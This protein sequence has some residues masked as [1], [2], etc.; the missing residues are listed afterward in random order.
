MA[1]TSTTA[2]PAQPKRKSV[3]RQ[4]ALTS[5]SSP[6]D[7]LDSLLRVT[8]PRGWLVLVALLAV[9][10][11][12]VLYGFVGAVPTTVSGQG[13]F[14]PPGGLLSV[15][16]PR[17]GTVTQMRGRVGLAV[18]PGD[19]VGTIAISE[20]DTYVVRATFSGVITEILID[21]GNFIS[22]GQALA[23]VEPAGSTGAVVYV[24]A[25]EGKAITPGM[26]VRLSP[27]TAPSEQYGQIEGVV[28]SVSQFPV[29]PRRLQ[30]VLQ[31][32]DLVSA[33]VAL[34]SVLEVN[35]V[36]T[37]DP[38]TRSGLKWTSGKGPPFPV[39]NGTLT[40]VSVI[41]DSESP[42]KKLFSPRE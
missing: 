24:A 32:A 6:S 28:G 2:P 22:A 20:H 36:V 27:S 7:Q 35:I 30:F 17:S 37:Q 39:G 34:G 1:E 41:L 16:A 8:S 13:L 40:S 38:T 29:S 5:L 23:I 25:G 14:L 21:A 10:A 15:D 18:Q 4:Q 42:A 3:F 9:V 12:T 11:A 33:I 26:R 19:E 31:N